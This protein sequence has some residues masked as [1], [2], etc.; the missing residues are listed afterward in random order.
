M[1]KDVRKTLEYTKWFEGLSDSRTRMKITARIM[2]LAEG[3]PGDSR[4][5]GKRLSE[6]RIDHGPG[7]RVYYM[8]TERE[9]IILL[10]GG[11]KSTQQ[12]D[13][14]KARELAEKFIA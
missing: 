1:P 5:L 12:G 2:R 3:N 6:L 8:E 9:I 4:F 7:Y 10:C 14:T 11:D 13:I